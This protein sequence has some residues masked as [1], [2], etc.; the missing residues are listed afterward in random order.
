MT[1]EQPVPL[2]LEHLKARPGVAS[3]RDQAPV[4]SSDVGGVTQ[5]CPATLPR[6][7][8]ATAPHILHGEH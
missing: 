8:L 4:G 6:T 2:L 1:G 3:E 7:S 5:T